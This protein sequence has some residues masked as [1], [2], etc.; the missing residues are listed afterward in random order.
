MAT[1][2]TALLRAPILFSDPLPH[3]LRSLSVFLLL[4]GRTGVMICAYMLHDK[5]FDTAK[6][7]LRF[8]EEARTQN[9]TVRLFT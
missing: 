3:F 6:D 1:H 8:Y 7:V 9:A 4:Q 2:A 5:L